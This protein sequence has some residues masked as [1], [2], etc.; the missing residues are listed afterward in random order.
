[1]LGP[2]QCERL[3]ETVLRAGLPTLVPHGRTT[4][5]GVDGAWYPPTIVICEDPDSELVQ[6]ESF[7]PVLVVQPARDWSEALALVNG[8]EQGLVAAL[9][10]RS[11]ASAERFLEEAQAGILKLNRSTADAELDV[12]FGGWKAS[13]VGPPEHGSF[14]ADFYTRPQTVY[15]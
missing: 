2:E 14:D 7:G 6:R 15:R 4:V 1:M 13:A 11:A 5:A 3:A 12:P 9:F 8:V 10:S